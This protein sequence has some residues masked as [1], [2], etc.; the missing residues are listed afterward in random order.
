M[1][2]ASPRTLILRGLVT[3]AFGLVLIGWPAISVS[4]LILLFAAFALVDGALMLMIGLDRPSGEPGRPAALIAGVLA[5]AVG[6]VAFVWP[7]L[8]ALALAVL[9]AVRAIIIGF[10]EIGAAVR[11]GWRA[12]GVS[13]LA[14]LGVLTIGFAVMLLVNPGLGIL[15]LMWAC[16]LRLGD[17]PARR[18]PGGARRASEIAS[19]SRDVGLKEAGLKTRLYV[20][21]SAFRSIPSC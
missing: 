16:G 4:V 17:G 19:A 14:I 15:A 18:R 2:Y 8:T 10:A 20:C 1:W 12:S 9:I 21:L 11:I 13:M 7:G 3:M 5:V 6:L